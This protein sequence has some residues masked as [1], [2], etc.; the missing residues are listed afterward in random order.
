MALPEEHLAQASAS[1]SPQRILAESFGLVEVFCGPNA[2]L[3]C[4]AIACEVR[5][6]PKIDLRRHPFWDIRSV[7]VIC[8]LLLKSHFAPPSPFIGVILTRK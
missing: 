1:L 4:A 8:W 5:C 2:P 6:G 7:R 3:T